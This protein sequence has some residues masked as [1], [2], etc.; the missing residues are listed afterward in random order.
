MLKLNKNTKT[1]IYSEFVYDQNI[2]H[3]SPLFSSLYF[4]TEWNQLSPVDL[5]TGIM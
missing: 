5:K 3:L 1:G 2:T 4:S